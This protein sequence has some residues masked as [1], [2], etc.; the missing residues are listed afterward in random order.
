MTKYIPHVSL[1]T[2]LGMFIEGLKYVQSHA[3]SWETWAVGTAIP[4]I[5]ALATTVQQMAQS[6]TVSF[7]NLSDVLTE[8]KNIK[9]AVNSLQR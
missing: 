1:V 8:L 2:F 4:A 9:L 3:L 5:I 6:K 7:G